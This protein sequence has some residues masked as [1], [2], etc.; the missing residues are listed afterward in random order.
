GDRE[1]AL[2]YYRA[3]HDQD[4]SSAE[5]AYALERALSE[6]GHF[7]E[8][9]MLI[10]QRLPGLKDLRE[11]YRWAMELARVRETRLGADARALEA[12]DLA[13]EAG[14]ESVAAVFGRM[15]C[16]GRLGKFAELVKE[17][18]R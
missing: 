14:P 7:D 4:P 10:E 15:R 9:A 12:I 3:A 16:L 1:R 18:D 6:A 2:E 8:V 11:R 5:A 13:L 17:T